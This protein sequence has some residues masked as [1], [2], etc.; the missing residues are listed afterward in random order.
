MDWSYQSF[1][2]W[3]TAWGPGAAAFGATSFGAPTMA[4][5]V[6]G[7]GNA[8]FSGKLAGFYLTPEGEKL[9]AAAN[10]AVYVDFSARSLDFASTRT[11]VGAGIAAPNLDLAGRLAYS[12][13]SAIFAGTLTTAGGTMSGP[14]TG[15][16]YGPAAEELGG[17]FSVKSPT[18]AEL[19]TGGY[20]AQR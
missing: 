20:G 14:S 17:T 1:G 9:L 13:G 8:T 18:T 2:A 11:T 5:G 4:S 19:F 16:Y 12:P 6:P 3:D 10:L 15:R 7:V